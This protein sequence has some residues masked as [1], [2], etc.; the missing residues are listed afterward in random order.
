[1][2]TIIVPTDFSAVATNAMQYAL[3]MAVYLKA[4]LVLFHTY[5]IPVSYVGSEVPLPIIDVVELERINNDK[6][7]EVKTYV[8]K[9]T[10][11]AIT[12][13]T[14][15]RNG[16]LVYELQDYSST[17][18]PFAIVMGTKGAGFVERL[19]LGSSTLSVIKKLDWPVWVVP[20][21][22]SFKPIT[23]LGLACDFKSVA[24]TT[25][26]DVIKNLVTAFN[27][28]LLVLNVDH[29]NKQFKPETPEQSVILHN[30]LKE[31]KPKYFFIDNENVEEGISSFAEQHHID[32]IITIPKKQSLLD[33]LFQKSHSAELAIHS[34]IP[35][36]AVHE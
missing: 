9:K 30:L 28:E 7:T 22:S 11:G 27:A 13:E 19:F 25:P 8:E 4:K 32:I 20:P 33:S 18:N 5:E 29:Q 21:G 36:I 26:T 15:L 3:D 35:I 16:D 23:K 14:E 1:M 31:V 34:H 2:K 24:E 12:I 6:L 10:A 17:V